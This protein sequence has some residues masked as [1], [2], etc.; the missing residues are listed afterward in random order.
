MKLGKTVAT[1]IALGALTACSGDG[2]G[3]AS[4][5]SSQTLPPLGDPIDVTATEEW[6]WVPVEGTVCADGTEAGVGV[7]FT[8]QSRDL[9]IWFQ[10]NGVCYDQT[11]CTVLFPHLLTGM[12]PD[13]LDHMWWGDKNTGHLGI[14]DRADPDN[15]LK[16]SNF[17]VFPHCGVDG[18]TADH[19]VDY[20]GRTVHQH[21]YANVTAAL[22]RIVPT[23][24]DAGRVVVAGFSAG[25]IGAGAN[26]HQIATLFE[27]VGKPPPF[28]IDD[29]GP[30]L[31]PP[32]LGPNAQSALRNGWG[33]DKTL[34]PWCSD[35][36]T[37]GYHAI[38]ETLARMHPGLRSSVVCAYGD[39]I[40]TP[41]YALL[42]GAP[43]DGSNLE[44][45]LRDLSEWTA[46]FQ[47]AVSP[48]VQREFLYPGVRHG[49]LVVAP[50]SATPGL[51]EFLTAQLDASPTWATVQ[52]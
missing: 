33:L 1:C 22:Q 16:A 43:F 41:L 42:N 8:T 29:G 36:A 34:E 51:T 37:E 31:R 15:P 46:S 32:Y 28:L 44:A 5:S 52:Q 7:N 4:G 2:Q 18:H 6:V 40:A 27:A 25:G 19:D 12:G 35:C 45:G 21:G 20:A 48:S 50:L 11:T 23:F 14:F 47:E 26:Y 3:P 17:V 10:G 49:A 39:G 30:V 24:L 38:H 13:P 9:V